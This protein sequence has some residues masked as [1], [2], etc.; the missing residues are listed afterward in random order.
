[1]L[2]HDARRRVLLAQLPPCFT[3]VARLAAGCL[4]GFFAAVKLPALQ[5]TN[6]MP[7][8]RGGCGV[9]ESDPPAMPST[10]TID[11]GS[12]VSASCTST[13]PAATLYECTCTAGKAQGKAFTYAP[14]GGPIPE[15]QGCFGLGDATVWN[16]CDL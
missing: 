13:T 5:C 1:V 14:V 3:E 7:V 15:N 6:G 8:Y 4:D 16:E 2:L 10:C 11:C 9:T 12:S